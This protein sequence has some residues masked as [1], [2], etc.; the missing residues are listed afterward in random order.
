MIGVNWLRSYRVILHIESSKPFH[1]YTGKIIKTL[2]YTVAPELLGI[3]GLKGVLSPLMV[4][5]PFKIGR[6]ECE[7]G[8]PVIPVYVKTM[9][10]SDGGTW[11]LEPVKLNGEYI[12]HIGGK[13]EIVSIV[14]RRLEELD[15]PLAVKIGNNIVRYKVEKIID[16]TTHIIE[17]ASSI[18]D[19]VRVYLKSPAQIFNVFTPTRLPK[20]TTSAVELLM[21]PYMIANNI[22]TIHASTLL[23]ASQILGQLVETWYSLRT[24]RPV[25]IPFKGK[26]EVVLSGYVTYII[27]APNKNTLEAIKKTLAVAEIAGIGRSRQ[28]GFGTTVIKA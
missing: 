25:M 11:K 7:L 13:K 12:T 22:Y 2:V 16:V 3:R 21:A 1:D 5:P 26:M 20:F 17:K 8:E 4:S 18:K 6:T 19:R 14:A 10:S 28:N 15:A 9:S 24:L 23:T 27:E